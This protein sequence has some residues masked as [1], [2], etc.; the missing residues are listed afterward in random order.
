M[1]ECVDC[2]SGSPTAPS[3]SNE[4]TADA[5]DEDADDADKAPATAALNL[6]DGCEANLKCM[7]SGLITGTLPEPA[8]D[9]DDDAPEEELADVGRLS[10]LAEE[11]PSEGTGRMEAADVDGAMTRMRFG[12]P[13]A[14]EAGDDG[15]ATV[16]TRT[17]LRLPE[18]DEDEDGPG[19]VCQDD[20]P[21]PGAAADADGKSALGATGD[22]FGGGRG[23]ADGELE[24]EAEAEAEGRSGVGR[25][26]R[27]LHRHRTRLSHLSYVYIDPN[28]TYLTILAGGNSQQIRVTCLPLF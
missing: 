4:T 1:A 2:M 13:A 17:F 26:E 12:P 3:S 19:G 6:D 16:T 22:G 10:D 18:E 15:G 9:D 21:S 8:L 20:G 27:V 11:N 25:A 14:V 24:A 7:E 28:R 5:D 23:G